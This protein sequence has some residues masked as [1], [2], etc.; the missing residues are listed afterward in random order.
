M[1]KDNK[2]QLDTLLAHASSGPEPAATSLI[3]PLHMTTSFKLPSFGPELLDALLMESDA[4]PYAYTRWGNPTV[5]ELEEKLAA[6]EGAE[7]ALVTASGMAAVSAVLMGMLK[8]GD[9]LVAQEL[10]YVGS[11]DLSGRHLKQY[12]ISVTLVD[13]TDVKQVEAAL[14]SNTKIIFAETPSNP[15]L[16]VVNIPALAEIARRAGVYLVVD[17]TFATPLLQRPLEMGADF[18]VHSLTKYLNGHGDALGGAIMGSMEEIKRLRKEMIIHLGGAASP[19]NAWLISR[20]LVTLSLRMERHCT[21]AM[22]LA[23]FLETHPA[24]K[25]VCYPGLASHPHHELAARQMSHFG[26]MLTFQLNEGLNAVIKLAEKIRIFSYATSLGHPHSLLFYYPTD[27]YLDQVEY[28]S[29][30]QKRRIREEWMGEG[31]VRVSTGLESAD[32]LISDLE[33]AMENK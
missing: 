4:P 28:I 24:V 27:I 17:S 12:G 13:T 6:L 18:V 26:G 16:R 14:Q 19:F 11:Q 15:L 33:Q 1:G 3:R 9:H 7:A 29:P 10:C 31:I 32:D 20:G 21:N 8:Q 22:A 5:K 2:K 23:R 25:R 30:D